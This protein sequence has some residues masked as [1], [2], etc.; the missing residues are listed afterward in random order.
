MRK[1][2]LLACCALLSATVP[3]AAQQSGNPMTDAM[4]AQFAI[5]KADLAKTA[6]QVTE[7]N[8][9]FKPTPD[10]R[11]LGALIGHVADA[12]Y[13]FCSTASGAA[14]PMKGTSVEKSKTSKADLQKALGEALAFCD[15][16]LNAMTDAK[17]AEMVD[18]F[19]GK[20]PRMAVFAFNTAHD[21][22]HYGNL[23]TY[24]RLKGMVPPS[25]QKG[26]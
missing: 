25:S 13:Y 18:F 10:V 19:G 6:E 14:N 12:S 7:E 5:V 23:V 2:A 26:M 16:Q 21:F 9:A 11:N 15:T 20:Q 4:K 8:Y 3:A 1:P 24:M 22:E 17:G